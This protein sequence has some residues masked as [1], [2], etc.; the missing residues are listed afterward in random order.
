MLV[1]VVE[2]QALLN[3][4]D[5][6]VIDLLA[7]LFSQSLPTFVLGCHPHLG[8][9]LHDLLTDGMHSTVELFD[10]S[11]TCRTGLCLSGQLGEE[12]L[13]CLAHTCQ[14][15]DCPNIVAGGPT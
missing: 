9:F 15:T 2:G 10:G 1:Y 3:H 8:G 14:A 13:E 6:E 4:H 12:F 11:R 7:D 5:L